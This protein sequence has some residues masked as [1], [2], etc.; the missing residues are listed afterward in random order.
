MEHKQHHI[1]IDYPDTKLGKSLSWMFS[2][3]TYISILTVVLWSYIDISHPYYYS[4]IISEYIFSIL[5]LIDFLIRFSYS[6]FSW[7]FFMSIFTFTD[8]L[9]FAPLLV[10]VVFGVRWVENFNIFRL[11]RVLRIFRVWK[12]YIFLRWLWEALQKNFY[13]YKIAFTLFF[14][15]WLIWSFLMYGIEVWYNPHIHTIPDAMRWSVVTMATI[16]YGDIVPVTLLWRAVA[17]SIIIFWPIFLSIITSI[18]IITFMDVMKSVA[19]SDASH[20]W[21]IC[22]LCHTT[23]QTAS[24]NFCSHCGSRL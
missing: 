18:T 10:W 9:S 3:L 22:A 13:K 21:R 1:C 8:I 12:Y 4:I 14:V 20:E 19:K 24:H 2:F 6:K 11:A 7:R 17:V 5:F 15:V 23:T 16:W